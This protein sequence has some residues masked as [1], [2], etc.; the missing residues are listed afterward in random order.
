MVLEDD[1][2][3]QESWTSFFT[4]LGKL[5]G[6]KGQELRQDFNS[7]TFAYADLL[8]KPGQDRLSYLIRESQEHSPT[9]T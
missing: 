7:S 4:F 8:E 6:E 5:H 9:I 2:S 1:L 3:N